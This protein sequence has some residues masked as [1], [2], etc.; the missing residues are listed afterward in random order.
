MEVFVGDIFGKGRGGCIGLPR[1]YGRE[2][3]GA[4]EVSVEDPKKLLLSCPIP[5][6]RFLT[7]P[8][9]SDLT[10]QSFICDQIWHN[11]PTPP[12]GLVASW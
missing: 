1:L 8:G 7:R 10:G 4:E 11:K 2:K 9:I 12:S 5:L 3:L 6:S